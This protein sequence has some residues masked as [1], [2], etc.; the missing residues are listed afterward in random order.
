MPTATFLWR[1]ELRVPAQAVAPFE[2]SLSA[3]CMSVSSFAEGDA[4]DPDAD[5]RIEGFT[6]AEPDGRALAQR[7]AKAAGETGIEAPKAKIHLVPPRDWAAENMADF[8]PS[9]SGAISFTAPSSRA[10]RRRG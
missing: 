7:L 2:E 6:G 8:P 3:D 4:D 10:A 5:W 1:I 9:G